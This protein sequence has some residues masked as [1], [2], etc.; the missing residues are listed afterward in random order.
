MAI[1]KCPGVR[2]VGIREIIRRMIAKMVLKVTG[3]YAAEVC[4]NYQLCAGLEAGIEGAVHAARDLSEGSRIRPESDGE[5]VVP[6]EGG[7]LITRTPVSHG[8]SRC[9]AVDS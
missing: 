8:Q 9:I 2:L 3:P 6:R 1:N 4:R 5:E 7:K